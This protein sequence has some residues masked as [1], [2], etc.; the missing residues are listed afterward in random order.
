MATALCDLDCVVTGGGVAAAGELLLGPLRTAVA[1]RARL[2][3][4]RRL[5]T[6]VVPTG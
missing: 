1:D 2:D 4:T 3:F 5:R 6:P